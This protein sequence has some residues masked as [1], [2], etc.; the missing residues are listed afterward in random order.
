MATYTLRK[1]ERLKKKKQIDR[2]FTSG[3][4]FYIFP[5][6]VYW[7]VLD[8]EHPYPAEVLI[9]ASKRSMKRAVRRNRIKR[10][11]RE[12]YRHQ[13]M[14][15]YDLLEEH[16]WHAL[17]GIIYTSPDLMNFDQIKEKI[18]RVMSRLLEEVKNN[19]QNRYKA[20]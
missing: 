8:K 5:F 7:L 19:P 13:K 2:L 15:F 20:Q 10:L 18:N 17:V 9:S 6:K 3:R 12:A 1:E 11:V 16:Q 4:S 14:E